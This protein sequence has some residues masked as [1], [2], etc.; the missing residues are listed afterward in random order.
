MIKKASKPKSKKCL[1]ALN[2]SHDWPSG[3]SYGVYFKHT[4]KKEGAVFF[5]S[6]FV[7]FFFFITSVSFS[8]VKSNKH[9]FKTVNPFSR[10]TGFKTLSWKDQMTDEQNYSSP[11]IADQDLSSIWVECGWKFSIVCIDVRYRRQCLTI[12]FGKNQVVGWDS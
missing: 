9:R 7:F 2:K 12:F 10:I 1:P 8:V 5:L 4:K 11:Q 3:W 6:D